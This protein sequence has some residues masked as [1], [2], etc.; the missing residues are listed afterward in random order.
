MDTYKFK[1][2][3]ENGDQLIREV[4]AMSLLEAWYEILVAKGF[5]DVTVKAELIK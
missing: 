3:N 4:S 5:G 1:L 2:I